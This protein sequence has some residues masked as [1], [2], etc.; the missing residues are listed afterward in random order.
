MSAISE[1]Y[2]CDCYEYMRTLPDKCFDL[3]IADPPYGIAADAR[4]QNRAGKQHGNAA[5]ASRDYGTVQSWDLQAPAQEVFDEIFR[6]SRHQV[7]FG[8]NH[9]ISR[10]PYDASCWL[11]WDKDNGNNGYADCELAWTSFPTAVRKFRYTWHGMIQEDMKHKEQRIHPTQKPVSLY[12]WII[13]TY[14]P[15]IGGVKSSTRF[16]AVAHH[17][18]Q[19]TV[20][21]LTS[22]AAS[23]IRDITRCSKN[24]SSV[25]VST[26]SR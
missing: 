7:I 6:V 5:A 21:T 3:C 25:S 1:T 4:Q 23:L 15:K 26:L 8:A 14:I 22:T 12:R 18:L 24:A 2:N 13:E 20:S 10:M 19:H 16:S 11:V 9:F 17:V